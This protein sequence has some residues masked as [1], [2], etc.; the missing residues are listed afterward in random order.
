MLSHMFLYSSTQSLFCPCGFSLPIQDGR[1]SGEGM[2]GP[3]DLR[4]PSVSWRTHE[5][6]ETVEAFN[7]GEFLF[8]FFLLIEQN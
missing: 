3:D 8:T 2:R 4:L 6:W 7:W 1:G 5:L